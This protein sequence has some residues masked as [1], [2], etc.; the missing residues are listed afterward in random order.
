VRVGSHCHS[1]TDDHNRRRIQDLART[2]RKRMRS[3][4]GGYRRDHLR[5]LTQRVKV[6]QKELR[7]MGSKA[8]SRPSLLEAQKRLVWRAQFRTEMVLH[9]GFEPPPHGF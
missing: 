5:A 3:E 4:N 8:C 7:I 6:D 9:D 2:A 1:A